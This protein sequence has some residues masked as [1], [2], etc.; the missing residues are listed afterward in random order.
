MPRLDGVRSRS[1]YGVGQAAPEAVV[2]APGAQGWSPVIGAVPVGAAPLPALVPVVVDMA[3]VAPPLEPEAGWS[4]VIGAVPGVVASVEPAVPAVPAALP[5][6]VV[7]GWSPVIGAAPFAAPE[8]LV[9]VCAT[10]VPARLNATSA[11]VK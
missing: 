9:P 8:A 1:D 10:A 11:A 2:V 4:P 7:F 6:A 5:A 3:P